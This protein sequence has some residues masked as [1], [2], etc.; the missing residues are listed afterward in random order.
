MFLIDY[1][2]ICSYALLK[3]LGDDLLVFR[4]VGMTYILLVMDTIIITRNINRNALHLLKDNRVLEI[5]F[6]VGLLLLFIAWIYY[7]KR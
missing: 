7:N 4:A 5:I 6:L 1:L 3:N 2:F